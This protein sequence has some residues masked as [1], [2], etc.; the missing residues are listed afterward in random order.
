[1]GDFGGSA[2]FFL[3]S[4]DNSNWD[5][6]PKLA[7]FNEAFNK[8]YFFFLQV[9][10]G[11]CDT[12]VITFY[13]SFYLSIIRFIILTNNVIESGQPYTMN[14]YELVHQKIYN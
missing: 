1:M 13:I 11:V 6:D 12:I 14:N 3:G 5:K 8:Y 10:L 7:L 9:G 4:H 2:S